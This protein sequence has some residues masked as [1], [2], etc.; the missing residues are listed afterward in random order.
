MPG[1][2][3]Q[4]QG[5]STNSALQIA[6]IKKNVFKECFLTAYFRSKFFFPTTFNSRVLPKNS[7]FNKCKLRAYTFF[8]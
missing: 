3:H 2:I 5:A 6:F 7:T 4:F 1:R 8:L